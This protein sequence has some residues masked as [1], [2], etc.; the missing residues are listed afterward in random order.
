MFSDCAPN[1][2]PAEISF[3]AVD[4]RLRVRQREEI[5]NL[6]KYYDADSYYIDD[7]GNV[8]V[9]NNEGKI[10]DVDSL[11]RIFPVY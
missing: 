11:G 7:L 1:R 4:R 2:N 10:A 3:A 9:Y 5:L 6:A 8:E